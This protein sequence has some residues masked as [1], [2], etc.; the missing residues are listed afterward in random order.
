MGYVYK[1]SD[2]NLAFFCQI[3]YSFSFG[4]LCKT[5]DLKHYSIEADSVESKKIDDKVKKYIN[6]K[7]LNESN[8]YKDLL[9]EK[10]KFEKKIS[11]F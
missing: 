7:V 2:L 9:I 1:F 10:N 4:F 5:L 3:I 6:K 8:Y 11:S